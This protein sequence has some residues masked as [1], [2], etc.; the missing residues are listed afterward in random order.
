MKIYL[1]IVYERNAI[2]ESCRVDR[3]YRTRKAADKRASICQKYSDKVAILKHSYHVIEKTLKGK[4]TGKIV[5]C[6][7][8]KHND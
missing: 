5:Y 7:K 3:A 4:A 8:L 2:G 6:V 1:V